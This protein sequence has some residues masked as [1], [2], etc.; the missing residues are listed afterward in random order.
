MEPGATSKTYISK[1]YGKT[2]TEVSHFFQLEDGLTNATIA[3][4]YHHPNS[5]CHYVFTDTINKYIFTTNDCGENIKAYNLKTINPSLVAFEKNRDTIF[6]IHDLKSEE[7]RLYVTKTFG[8]TFSP[9]QDYV[10]S[11]FFHYGQV[12]ISEKIKI[13]KWLP[14]AALRHALIKKK[15]KLCLFRI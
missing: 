15:K 12:I 4:F 10:K 13:R 3:K 5:N 2:F 6:L 9:V 7:K 11:F 1:D 8:Q 14:T